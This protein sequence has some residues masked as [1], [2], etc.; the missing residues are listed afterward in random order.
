MS[1][2]HELKEKVKSKKA[3]VRPA[4]ATF[5]FF[6]FPFALLVL[7]ITDLRYSLEPGQKPP[8]LSAFKHRVARLDAQEETI[9]ACH[10]KA[11]NV[12]HRMIRLRQSVQRQHPKHRGNRSQQNR[13]FECDR[14]ERRPTVQRTPADVERIDVRRNPVAQRVS[15]KAPEYPANQHDQRQLRMLDAERLGQLFDRIR[16]KRIHSPVARCVGFAR[17]F[18]DCR[19]GLELGHHAIEFVGF[20]HQLA[21]NLRIEEPAT[22]QLVAATNSSADW[23]DDTDVNTFL[24]IC[25]LCGICGPLFGD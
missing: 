7:D 13:A 22:P 2:L 23:S 10:L 25:D 9:A 1:C 4:A 3:K 18:Y 6:L 24:Y 17:S 21:F 20:V 8:R 15:A 11:V 19:R 5:S 14:D 12:E 16:R